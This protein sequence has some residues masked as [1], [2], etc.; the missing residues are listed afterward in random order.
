MTATPQSPKIFIG[1]ECSG[2]VRNA[3]WELCPDAYVVS[4]DHKPAED[5]CGFNA[6]SGGHWIGDMCATVDGFASDGNYFD[7]GL[8]HPD[9]T[10]LTNSAAWAFKDG[11]YHQKVK[12]ET[13][14]GAA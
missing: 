5:K 8:W 13:L 9:C 3:I 4:C 1:G 6:H 14:V 10:Y 11:P 12:P 2:R 7:A